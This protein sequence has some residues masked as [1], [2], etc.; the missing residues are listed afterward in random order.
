MKKRETESE[1]NRRDFLRVIAGAAVGSVWSWHSRG[2]EETRGNPEFTFGVA[3]DAQYGDC[4]S[5]GTR[6]YRAS[7]KKLAECVREFNAGKVDFAVHLGD[8]IEQDFTSFDSLLPIWNKLTMPNYHVLGN[9]D[10]SGVADEYKNAV[11]AKLGM[12]SRYYDFKVKGWRFVVLDGNDLSVG[13]VFPREGNPRYEEGLA[14][15]KKVAAAG[16]PNAHSYNGGM[17]TK[18]VAWLK[19]KL[20]KACHAGEKVILFSHFPVFPPN[21]H[22]LWNDDQ[23]LE[24]IESY[25]CVVAY[26]NGHNHAGNYGQK[27]GVH[28]LTLKGMCET[29]DENAYA[30][31]EVY[32]DRLKV[33]GYAREP[34]R[35][36][37][38]KH[39]P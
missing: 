12:K 29:P 15:Q 35:E 24:V 31:V 19:D 30:I 8:F 37:R 33:V 36:L 3:A 23:L 21:L 6:H 1:L 20:Q 10:L 4:P 2:D 13:G 22:N 14:M 34:D 7:L 28:Y 9:H 18:H 25:E 38:L 16:K 32:D 17:G 5:L 26:V 39:A 27:D 11:A